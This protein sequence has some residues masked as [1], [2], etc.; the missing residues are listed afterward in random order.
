MVW[1]FVLVLIVGIIVGLII[2][3]AFQRI[4]SIGILHII[5]TEEEQP[6]MF[7]ELYDEIHKFHN[8]KYVTMSIRENNNAYYEKQ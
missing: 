1:Q 8:K 3:T 2:T 7:L 6:G 4:N 5:H